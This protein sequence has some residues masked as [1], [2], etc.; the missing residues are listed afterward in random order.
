MP[1]AGGAKRTVFKVSAYPKQLVLESGRQATIRPL[2]PADREEL[3]QFFLSIPACP[4]PRLSFTRL[5]TY[6]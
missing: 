6:R 3:R 5:L 2:Q 1:V 4:Y